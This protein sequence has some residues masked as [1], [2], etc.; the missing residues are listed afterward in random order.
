MVG[1]GIARPISVYDIVRSQIIV[2]AGMGRAMLAPTVDERLL[3]LTSFFGGGIIDLRERGDDLPKVLIT[4]GPT[5]ERIDSV[6]SITNHSTG[7]LGRE[8]AHAFA[9][10]G[11]EIF[12]LRGKG[13]V[14]YDLPNVH[15]TVITDVASLQSAI[16][17][18]FD[19]HKIDIII[20]AMAV[21]DYRPKV[22]YD[23]K[24]SSD[25]D[26]LVIVLEKNP[27]VIGQFRQLA[28]DAVFVG[29][30]LVTGLNHQQRIDKAHGLLAKNG[31]DFVLV[32]DSSKVGT[33]HTGWLVDSDKN[34]KEYIGKDA[35]AQGIV[36]EVW[37]KW[38]KST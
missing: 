35:I 9:V 12:Y 6:R 3:S 34:H 21:S 10:R 24:I 17:D 36:E 27:K 2:P 37:G 11:C 23:S 30:K 1:A 7:R 5:S 31:C 4:A 8:V 22:Q 16:S 32:N 18:I 29:F 38:T 20:H 19:K 26:E 14:S 25:A 33:D 28:P 15:E 13:G